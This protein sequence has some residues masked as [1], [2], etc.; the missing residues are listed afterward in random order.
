M[1]RDDLA[2]YEAMQHR[3]DIRFGREDSIWIAF[4]PELPGCVAHGATR[5]EALMR[6]EEFRLAWIQTA[7]E[8][9]TPIPEPEPEQTHSGKLVL[10]LPRRL[11]ERAARTASDEGVS[12]N[13]YLVQAVTEA[14]EHTGQLSLVR[15]L[16]AVLSRFLG[17]LIPKGGEGVLR[18]AFGAQFSGRTATKSL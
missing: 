14:V 7:L 3:V 15:A 4:Y 11:H 8:E 2:Y 12:L 13:T 6:G 16:E 9:Q 17:P 18:L 1:H 5:E 10:R